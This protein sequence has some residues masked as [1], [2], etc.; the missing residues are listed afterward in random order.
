MSTNVKRYHCEFKNC[1]CKKFKL[2]D[3]NLCFYCHHAGLWHSRK[4]K[5]LVDYTT[6]F[7]SPRPAA[8]TP[9]YDISERDI[10]LAEEVVYCTAIE[11]LPV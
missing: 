1:V 3:N 6:S 2:L 9:Q 7:I 5:Q 11:I 4:K 8:R 10:P